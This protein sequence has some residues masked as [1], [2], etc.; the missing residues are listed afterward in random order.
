[1]NIY[2]DSKM[3]DDDRRLKLY[4]G[5]ILVNSPC[6]SALKLC[7]LAQELIEEAFRPL[8]PLRVQETLPV[9]QCAKVLAALKPKF[10]HH[11]KS[12]EYIQAMLTEL[13]CDL[14]K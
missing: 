1:M 8:D 13:G 4:E 9:E 7:R 5:S 14:E 6:P 12:K 11:P 2:I 10:I 3:S